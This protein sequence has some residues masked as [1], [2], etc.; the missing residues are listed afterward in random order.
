[1]FFQLCKPC[2]IEKHLVLLFGQCVFF[3]FRNIFSNSSLTSIH[4]FFHKC[5]SKYFIVKFVLLYIVYLASSLYCVV[6]QSIYVRDE[7][8]N[9]SM[10]SV[11]KLGHPGFCKNKLIFL[12]RFLS[13]FF[14]VILHNLLTEY[15][16]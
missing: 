8:L 2:Y 7:N 3:I 5:I 6:S 16:D 11:P 12:D 1:M 13:L 10:P 4:L 15:S 14:I 9:P